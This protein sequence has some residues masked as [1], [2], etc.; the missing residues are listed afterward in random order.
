MFRPV[1][2]KRFRFPMELHWQL[3]V[4]SI[5]CLCAGLF[6]DSSL[7]S[8]DRLVCPYSKPRCPDFC[9]FVINKS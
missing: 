8:T 2:L 1:R 3:R 9:S 4:K 5:D 6:L 7:S